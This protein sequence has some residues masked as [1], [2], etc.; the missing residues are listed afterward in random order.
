MTD[1]FISSLRPLALGC[2]IALAAVAPSM[3]N[4]PAPQTATTSQP[5]KA[6]A[7]LSAKCQAMMAEHA[8]LMADMKSADERL[9][10][11]LSKM[12][13]ASG[14]EKV[15]AVAAVVSELVTQRKTMRDRMMS[16]NQS[17][18]GHMAEHMQTGPQSMAMC[19]MMKGHMK[20]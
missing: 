19:P 8:T 9:D 20:H 7:D 14:Q 16:M 1:V 4:G 11:L 6:P 17:M 18:M 2:A 15:D 12:H 10:T 3:A 5:Q 13:T